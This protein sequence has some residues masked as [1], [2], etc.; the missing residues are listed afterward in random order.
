MAEFSFSKGI[1]KETKGT[2]KK[3]G[4]KEI[5]RLKKSLEKQQTR[6]T[7]LQEPLMDSTLQAHD[8]SEMKMRCES[9]V[10]NIERKLSK[11]EEK[12]VEIAP[13]LERSI[14][15]LHNMTNT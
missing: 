14:D 6:G 12:D 5:S 1:L 7:K 10:R 9:E 4:K 11:L 2:D 15:L 13:K 3:Q 8:Y